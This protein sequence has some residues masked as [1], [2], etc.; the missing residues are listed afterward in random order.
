MATKIVAGAEGTL[1]MQS[2]PEQLDFASLAFPADRRV[3][4]VGEVAPV[5]RCTEQHV[6]DLL[7]EGKL[8]GFDIAGRHDYMRIPTAAIAAFAARFNVT[9]D[10]VLDIIRAVKPSRRTARAHWRIPVEGYQ[11]FLNENH[12]R[13]ERD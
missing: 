8:A 10:A 5:W 12:S 3:L 7:E 9:P 13:G 4:T 1:M 11:G 6:I 2:A